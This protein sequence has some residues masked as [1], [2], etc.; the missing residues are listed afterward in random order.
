MGA[1][2][3]VTGSSHLFNTGVGKVMVDCGMFQGP[4]EIEQRNFL[5]FGVAPS[6]VDFLVL[7]HAHIDHIGLVPRFVRLGFNGTILCTP[8]TRELAEILLL[9]SAHIQERDAEYSRKRNVERDRVQS[10]ALYTA[11]DVMRAM[12]LFKTAEYEEP[13]ELSR[14]ICARFRDAGHILGSSSVELTVRT[15]HGGAR[16]V[17]SGDI[18]Q[19]GSVILKDPKPFERADYLLMESTYGDRLHENLDDRKRL[20]A[21]EIERILDSGGPLIIPAFAV[22]RTQQLLY[23]L[24][25]LRKENPR[26]PE[27]PVF[28]DSPLASKATAILESHPECFDREMA[29]MLGRGVNPFHAPWLRFTEGVDESKELNFMREPRI[30]IAAS[31]MCTAGRIRHHLANHLAD[32]KASVLFVGYQAHGTLGRMLK[33]GAKEVTLFGEVVK[34]KARIAEIGG[35]SAHADQAGLL[36]WLE[37]MEEPPRNVYLVHGEPDAAAVLKTKVEGLGISCHVAEEDE[38]VTLPFT[39]SVRVAPAAKEPAAEPAPAPR[40]APAFA[41]AGPAHPGDSAQNRI[42][43]YLRWL[44]KEVNDAKFVISEIGAELPSWLA[45]PSL[46]LPPEQS[47]AVVW[48]DALDK[49]LP[50][51]YAIVQGYEATA[52][53]VSTDAVK[54][55]SASGDLVEFGIALEE[56]ARKYRRKVLSELD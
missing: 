40:A 45:D 28:V 34:V 53:N 4:R 33:E 6:D 9:D 3:T 37:A 41:L 2:G 20:L 1:A 21:D 26:W 36:G 22:G 30:I 49:V 35:F 7:T 48:D 39:R 12:R 19:P 52:S 11:D 42:S 23:M 25:E 55:E 50:L 13:F 43:R 47:A 31:G 44:D 56:L 8:A 18:G 5:G 17:A 10:A 38:T 14:H 54:G 32:K 15:A 29:A 16:I 24:A 46:P 51:V 27:F